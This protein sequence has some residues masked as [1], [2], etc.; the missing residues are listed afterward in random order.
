MDR[1]FSSRFG[2]RRVRTKLTLW[3][4]FV[5]ATVLIISWGLTASFLFLQLRSQL[6]HYAIQDI[7]TVEGLLY[8]DAEGKLNLREDYHNHPAS[9]QVL[10]RL[11]EVRSEDGAILYRNERL[12]GQSLGG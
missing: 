8:F 2:V 5:L 11:L 3:Y 12:G 1:S 7:E 6:D 4:V 10:E 9:K